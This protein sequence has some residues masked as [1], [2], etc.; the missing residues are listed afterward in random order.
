MLGY[1]KLSALLAA[2]ATVYATG[3]FCESSETSVSCYNIHYLAKCEEGKSYSAQCPSGS[4]CSYETFDCVWVSNSTAVTDYQ[5]DWVYHDNMSS[6][7][8]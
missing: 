1:A 4:Y 5:Y 7:P 2:A 6:V 3:E 8:S